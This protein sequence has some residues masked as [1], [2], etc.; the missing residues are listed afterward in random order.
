MGLS[1]AQAMKLTIQAR[2]SDCSYQS[3]AINEARLQ[4]SNKINALFTQQLNLKVAVPPNSQDFIT[5]IYRG[6]MGNCSFELGT[7]APTQDGDYTVELCF[8]NRG[9]HLELEGSNQIIRRGDDPNYSY[10]VGPD[11]TNE[12]IPYSQALGHGIDEDSDREYLEA[13]RRRWPDRFAD[14]DDPT[15]RDALRVYLTQHEGS[16]IYTPHFLLD[17]EV[18]SGGGY[19]DNNV[20]WAVSYTYSPKGEYQTYQSFEHAKLNFNEKGLMTSIALPGN[21][22]TT[23]GSYITYQLEP[24]QETDEDAYNQ[25]YNQYLKDQADYDK[26]MR[27]IDAQT[28]KLNK[29]DKDLELRL[30]R[31]NTEYNALKTEMDSID[32][33]IKD[34]IEKTFKGM[35]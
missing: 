6:A 22:E 9:H 2:M 21:A 24:V 28:E 4:V 10:Y 30:Q 31:L 11:G 33:N 5:T 18:R 1:A 35:T 15:I 32:Q 20:G 3:M 19:D 7:V 17:S 26:A 12:I 13:A 29:E 34:T 25:A 16:D 14:A 23:N 8:T 27:E